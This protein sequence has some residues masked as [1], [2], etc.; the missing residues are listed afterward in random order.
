MGSSYEFRSSLKPYIDEYL[1]IRE[2][3]LTKASLDIGKRYLKSFDAFLYDQ[4]VPE[5]SITE[6]VV[7]GWV[8]GLSSSNR[9]IVNAVSTLRMF[10]KYL[11]RCG[12]N[13]FIPDLPKAH[14]NYVPYLYSDGEVERIM[15]LADSGWVS[16]RN[17]CLKIEMPMMLRLLQGCGLRVSEALSLKTGD[18]D[19]DRGLLLM[20]HTKRAK[21]RVVPMHLRLS[22]IL[23]RYCLALGIYHTPDSWLF[24]NP[25]GNHLRLNYVDA[26]FKKVLAEA[27]IPLPARKHQRGPCLHCFRHLFAVRS[28]HQLEK[29]G[30]RI[31]DTVPYL[32]VYLGHENLME[33]EKYLKF[34]S[35]VFPDEIKKFSAYTE[36]LFPEVDYED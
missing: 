12:I 8:A 1:K 5:S 19:F 6:A 10:L 3:S 30:I 9:T 25:D 26:L 20:K 29:Q 34:S 13:V 15:K 21:Q 23:K 31:D 22:E 35:D 28:F 24:P 17:P 18:V 11:H 2:A 16:G 7:Y 14:D 4:Q 32:S 36:G 33:T 27:S